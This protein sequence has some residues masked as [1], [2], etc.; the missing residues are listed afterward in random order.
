M[1]EWRCIWCG[2]RYKT[3]RSKSDW[4]QESSS[5]GWQRLC[6]RCA[7]RRLGNTWNAILP[8]RKVGTPEEKYQ[9]QRKKVA[10]ILSDTLG[11][12]L[13]EPNA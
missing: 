4:E 12:R 9:E 13:E 6:N 11:S 3:E 7:N 5:K 10:N 2:K 8:M 1:A